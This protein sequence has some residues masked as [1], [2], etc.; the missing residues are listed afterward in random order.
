[1]FNSVQFRTSLRL[2]NSFIMN[3]MHALNNLGL[4]LDGAQ[5][6][7]FPQGEFGFKSHLGRHEKHP[8]WP[9]NTGAG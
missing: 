6:S 4:S 8:G 5:K 7:A 1:M 2:F 9:G 3:A